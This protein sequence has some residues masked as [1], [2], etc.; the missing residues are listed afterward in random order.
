MKPLTILCLLLF[1]AL[2]WGQ[3]KP[4]LRHEDRVRIAEAYRL[5]EHAGNDV[6]VDWDKSPFAF[7][8]VT[9]EYEFLL[10]HPDPSPDFS[11]LGYDELLKSEVHYRKRVYSPQLLAT[12]PAVNGYSTIVIGQAEK[13]MAKS[14]T[15]WVAVALHEHFHQLQYSQPGYYQGVDKLNL[16]RG[17]QSGM[18]MLNYPF[19][20]D[21]AVVTAAFSKLC[22]QLASALKALGSASFKGEV[23][24]YL[25]ARRGFKDILRPDDYRYFSFQ[26]W[27]EGISRYTEYRVA[28]LASKGYVPTS[29]FQQLP[30]FTPFETVAGNLRKGIVDILPTVNL[31]E[32]K[33]SAFYP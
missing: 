16:S 11:P 26:L 18:W 33:R 25:E 15:P 12:F 17:D 20:Y 29:E 28:G 7:L 31:A 32:S 6:W 24:R 30:D 14:S 3:E 8:L 4:S 19:P 5:A 10:H 1:P 9:P 13:T 21:S 22:L 2:V 23:D 27:Q